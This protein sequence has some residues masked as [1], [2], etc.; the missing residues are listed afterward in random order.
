[1]LTHGG[2]LFHAFLTSSLD[3][4]EWSASRPG[5]FIP[6]EKPELLW[7]RYKNNPRFPRDPNTD[8]LVVQHV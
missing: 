1:M 3:G 6:V 7:M 2:V 4:R 5:S 8:T